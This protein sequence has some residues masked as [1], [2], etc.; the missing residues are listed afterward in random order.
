MLTVEICFAEDA[1]EQAEILERI[2]RSRSLSSVHLGS[3]KPVPIVLLLS[4]AVCISD[5]IRRR[6]NAAVRSGITIYP[7]FLQKMELPEW[8]HFLISSHQWLDASDGNI[9]T[10]ALRIARKLLLDTDSPEGFLNSV[11]SLSRTGFRTFT[12]RRSTNFVGRKRELSNLEEAIFSPASSLY[13]TEY[14]SPLVVCVKGDA[15]VGKTSMI[16]TFL[17]DIEATGETSWLSVSS[18]ADDHHIAYMLWARVV[19]ELAGGEAGLT[20]LRKSLEKSLGKSFDTDLVKETALLLPLLVMKDSPA[21]NDMKELR[22]RVA[23]FIA[24]LLKASLN[25]GRYILLLDNLHWADSGSIE[26]LGE[27]LVKLEG[28]PLR[29]ILAYRPERPDGAPVEIPVSGNVTITEEILLEPLKPEESIE[30]LNRL[31]DTDVLEYRELAEMAETASGW[32]LHLE[33]MASAQKYS[34]EAQSYSEDELGDMQLL[35]QKNF[36]R[37]PVERRSIVQALSVLGGEAP[38]ALVLDTVCTKPALGKSVLLQNDDFVV[39]KQTSFADTLTFRHDILREAVYDTMGS[40]TRVK[41]HLRAAVLLEELHLNDPRFSCVVSRH[42]KEA[43]KKDNVLKHATA[44]LKYV[45]SIFHSSA[46]LAWAG[47]VE[48]LIMELGLTAVNADDLAFALASTEE[49]LGRMGRIPQRE[50]TLDRLEAI[51]TRYNL[52]D[53]LTDAYCSRGLIRKDQGRYDEAIEFVQKSVDMAESH[54]N[55]YRAACALGALGSIISDL[56]DRLEEAEKLYLRAMELLENLD[57]PK[58]LGI[59]CMHLGILYTDMGRND[60]AMEY[61]NRASEIFRDIGFHYGEAAVLTNTANIYIK[62]ECSEEALAAMDKAMVLFRKAGDIHSL[63]I[64]LGNR[65]NLFSSQGDLEYATKE[66]KEAIELHMNADNSRSEKKSRTNFADCLRKRGLFDSA[67]E[68]LEKADKL[69]KHSGDSYWMARILEG[70]GRALLEKGLLEPAREA[71]L[72][73]LE[74]TRRNQYKAL[75]RRILNS[76]AMTAILSDNYAV[77]EEYCSICLKTSEEGGKDTQAVEAEIMISEIMLTANNSREAL[78][79]TRR[80]TTLAKH[81]SKPLLHAAAAVAEGRVLYK[82]GDVRAGKSL[83]KEATSI[84]DKCGFGNLFWFRG[85]EEF[86]QLP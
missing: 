74:I 86:R 18:E 58:D 20:N 30:L 70:R 56:R 16:C 50:K 15:G 47:E 59:N 10:A 48:Y 79:C 14:C 67:L 45:N 77:A 6:L 11:D 78:D 27:I 44:Y 22:G 7:V 41:Y 52:I 32:P 68:E 31:I 83:L 8:L 2:L 80:A 1:T 36:G 57:A 25:Q 71:L 60:K 73:S 69:N 64:T 51:A 43:G 21:P 28:T 40:T 49:T 62:L 9:E 5:S 34:P 72:S 53:R 23:C 33:L 19:V 81:M 12:V 24:E 61:C 38:V 65:A 39:R 37:L 84:A 4:P 55:S 29:V 75:E 17:K 35:I 3:D 66:Y 42:W 26:M 85:I 82:L 54:G 76:L 63:A 46:V 13:D